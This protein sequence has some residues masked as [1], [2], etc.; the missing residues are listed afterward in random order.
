MNALL[1]DNISG[2]REIKSF[3]QEEYEE[4]RFENK[5]NSYFMTNISHQAQLTSFPL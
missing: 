4:K 5:S 1:Q 2:I 3:A